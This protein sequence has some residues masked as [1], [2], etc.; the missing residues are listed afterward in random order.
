MDRAVVLDTQSVSQRYFSDTET[1][2]SDEEGVAQIHLL[3]TG[4]AGDDTLLIRSPGMDDFLLPV[5]ILA[6]GPDNL[7]VTLN[8]KGVRA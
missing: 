1:F 2:V 4:R 3:P 6:S 7:T 5:S 8:K